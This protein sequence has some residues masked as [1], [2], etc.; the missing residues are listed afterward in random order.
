MAGSGRIEESTLD[1][2][3]VATFVRRVGGEGVP[4]V[5]VHGHPTHS[6]DWVPFLERIEGPAVALDLPG[7][8]RSER[9]AE[10]DYTFDGLAA[11]YGR[12]LDELGIAEHRLVV[13][14]WGALA[15]IAAQA[16]PDR[17]RRLVV[18]NAVPLFEDFR[19]HWV[20]RLWRRRGLGELTY[21][22]QTRPAA[23]LLLRQASGDRG[24]MPPEFVDSIW[25]YRQRGTGRPV[26]ELYRSADPDR[27]AEAGAGL[28][29]VS[30][31]ALVVWGQRDPYLGPELGR[32]YASQFPN[33][34]LL[35]VPNG[36]HWPWIDRPEV[37]NQVVEFL[38]A[39]S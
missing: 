13:H 24:P 28:G 16:Q 32:A 7:W 33:A 27:L 31:P 5:F 37:V 15:L 17:V 3:G 10:F 1:V 35:E 23:T 2:D 12:F 22:T 30:C 39:A 9:P 6:Q 38:D 11:F 20:A 25:R 8:G 21:L 34:E 29:E 36:G 19:W 26:L 4:T 18:I 14:D